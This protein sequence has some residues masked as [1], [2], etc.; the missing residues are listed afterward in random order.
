MT[1]FRVT[2]WKVGTSLL[3]IGGAFLF[4]FLLFGVIGTLNAPAPITA[5]RCGSPQGPAPGTPPEGHEA[6]SLD[7]LSP[8]SHGRHPVA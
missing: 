6:A 7:E 4:P 1:V 2:S 3:V 8:G 5:S